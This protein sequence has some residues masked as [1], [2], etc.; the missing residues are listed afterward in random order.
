MRSCGNDL[1]YCMRLTNGLFLILMIVSP[2][3]VVSREGVPNS[4]VQ[5]MRD[6]AITIP[7]GKT[8][9][10]RRGASWKSST[11]EFITFARLENAARLVAP[12]TRD[13][14]ILLIT[15]LR[16]E[17]PCLRFIATSA[18]RD[19]SNDNQLLNPPTSVMLRDEEDPLRVRL[20]EDV[21]ARVIAKLFEK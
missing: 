3:Q 9:L 12:T 13:E 15:Y 11:G 8:D 19:W 18:L 4:L 17:N 5:K 21:T 20:S 16:H 6:I 14:V 2:R 10:Q 1:I 7:P